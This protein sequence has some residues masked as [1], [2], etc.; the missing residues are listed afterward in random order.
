MLELLEKEDD[1]DGGVAIEYLSGED[2]EPGSGKTGRD[3]ANMNGN[4][5]HAGLNGAM[6]EEDDEDMMGDEY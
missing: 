6:M 5:N 4:G 3:K 1:D 2:G